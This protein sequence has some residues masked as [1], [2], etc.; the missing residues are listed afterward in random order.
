M[1]EIFKRSKNT[2]TLLILAFLISIGVI[3][4]EG[5]NFSDIDF[6]GDIRSQI[7][8][9]LSVTYSFYEYPTLTASHID[10]NFITGKTISEGSFPKFEHEEELLV[11]WHYFPVGLSESTPIPSN[12]ILN[13]KNYVSSFVAG[14]NSQCLSAVWKKKCVVTFVSNWPGLNVETQI[15][16]EGER[17]Q[18]PTIEYRQGNYRFWGWYIDPECTQSWIFDNPVT[19]SMT[20]YGKWQEVRTITYYKNDGSGEYREMDYGVDSTS[21]IEDCMFAR[22]GYGFAGWSTTPNGNKNT[23]YEPGTE[24]EPLSLI[25]NNQKLYA[26]WTTDVVT[27][28]YIDS[29][30]TFAN[31]TAVYGRG[32][33][34]R[35]GYV[36]NE[37]NSW[38]EMLG[39]MWQIDGLNIAGYSPS[40]TKPADFEYDTGGWYDSD[41]DGYTDTNYIT[42]TN[43]M[44]LYVYW[45]G[46]TFYV[47]YCYYDD[48]GN[49]NNFD[50]QYVEWNDKTN[51]PTTE[52]SLAGKIFDGWYYANR[53]WN[54]VTG[55]D[56]Y[57][58]SSTPFDFNTRF[59]RTSFPDSYMVY[60]FAKF[61]DA[62]STGAGTVTFTEVRASDITVTIDT[63]VPNQISFTAPSYSGTGVYY[64]WYLN[65]TLDPSQTSNSATF[66]YSSWAPGI[67][68]L[69]LICSD[70]SN[71]YSY[72]GKIQKN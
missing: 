15:L 69:L 18:Y 35:V 39:S 3:S 29:T 54:P 28:T 23:D 72:Q 9:D 7:Q 51:P 27:I 67:Y 45:Q 6:N 42:I 14:N 4:C 68:D 57:I 30:H 63:S 20:L 16:P 53:V 33:K 43:N 34:V 58:I 17:L 49:L 11:G 66:N 22:K 62:G 37:E 65:D 60:L 44:T 41:G 12:F 13:G 70:G 19:D 64:S 25:Q 46:I 31:K 24:F 26:V 50:Y 47:E 8:N 56:E 5:F 32:A 61:A 48:S 59:N 2:L 38:Y 10:K 21:I 40:S 55:E 1:R 52:P 71:I 36:V